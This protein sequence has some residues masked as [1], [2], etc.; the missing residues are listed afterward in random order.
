MFARG[1]ATILERAAPV[2]E[3][4]RSAAEIEPEIADLLQRTT[5]E[6]WGNMSVVIQHV[7]ANGPL[8]DELDT[9]RA[10]ATIWTLTS[11]QVFLLLTRDRGWSTEQ[12]ADWLNDS[13]I[14]LLLP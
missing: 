10:V 7:A 6:R 5:R 13:L 9:E 8:R 2:F 14:R 11:A 1:I 12:Y 4:M 3:M